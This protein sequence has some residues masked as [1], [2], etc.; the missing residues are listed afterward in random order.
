MAAI[1]GLLSPAIL[2]A[3]QG[4]QAPPEQGMLS[5]GFFSRMGDGL[6]GA[7]NTGAD[8]RGLIGQALLG[9]AAGM[10]QTG[11][12]GFMGA[13]GNGLQSGLLAMN[14]G[15]ENLANER[16]K[17]AL[18][19]NQ[20]G[21]PAG[22]RETHL[23]AIA[24]GYEPGTQGYKDFF[25]RKNRE[26]AGQSSAAISYQKV[27]G[28][29]GREYLVA[30]DPRA[31]GAQTIGE[32]TGYGSFAPQG[33]GKS[34]VFRNAAG[35]QMDVSQVPDQH[36]RMEIMRN[37]EGFGLVPDGGSVELPGTYVPAPAYPRPSPT[38]GQ[39]PFASRRPE[40]EAAATRA[41]EVGV[42]LA[43]AGA[44]AEA[45]AQAAAAKEQAIT[46]VKPTKA[47]EAVDTEYGKEYVAFMQGGAADA[48]KALTE[49]DG[50][51]SALGSEKGLTGPWISTLPMA[52]RARTNPRSVDVQE[53]VESTVQRSLRAILGA[54]FTEKEGERIIARAYNPA[55]DE[56]Q[57]AE[58]VS[59]LAKQLREGLRN[60]AAMAAYYEQNGSLRGFQGK[61]PSLA[62]FNFDDEQVPSRP[63]ASAPT[64]SDDIDAL[65][66]IYR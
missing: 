49:L 66:E 29:D 21:D 56:A 24:A 12:Q 33:Q 62:E 52:V 53:T 22:Y 11:G 2:A 31:V 39:N 5:P 57:N 17:G 19:A 46:G 32:D 63:A 25:R 41:A 36:L 35:E 50:A 4:A 3:M 18:I 58:R 6:V 38:A 40:D 15:R 16:Y 51:L 54:Q 42:D 60:K 26:I 55:L 61:I 44:R 27:K 8:R 14:Q 47:Q 10:A 48:D 20:G 65:L 43:Y 59:R 30:L 13:L 34:T 37:P 28:P 7:E 64:S 45:D 23:S 9:A 1:Q